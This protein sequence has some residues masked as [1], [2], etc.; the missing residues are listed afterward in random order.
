MRRHDLAWLTG[1][2]WD[3][4]HRAHPD[5][6]TSPVARLWAERSWP[7]IGRRAL[8]GERTGVALG[9]PLPPSADRRRIAVL[10]APDAIAATSPPPALADAMAAAPA[11][12]HDTLAR[13]VD[14]ARRHG[15]TARVY[16]S[17]AFQAITGLGYLTDR[18]DLDLLIEVAPGTDLGALA[19]ALAAAAAGSP[20]PVDGELVGP[21]GAAIKW[22]EVLTTDGLLLIRTSDG[23]SLGGADRLFGTEATA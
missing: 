15:A 8:L 1:P 20:M 23:L 18:S 9:L 21:S 4:V 22:R 7:L 12:W 11:A 14:I 16:G 3:S 10:V 13:L 5:L 17:L 6:A 19:T 2:G